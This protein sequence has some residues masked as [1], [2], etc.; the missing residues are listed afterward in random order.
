MARIVQ[1]L[2]GVATTQFE[3]D[4]PEIRIGRSPECDVFIDDTSVSNLHCV[5][6]TVAATDENQPPE[7]HIRD[8]DS[9]NGTYVNIDRVQKARLV[10]EDVIR[11]GLKNFKFVDEQS[12]SEVK[13]ARIKKSWIP[14]VY[15]TKDNK[16]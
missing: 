4:K 1:M 13:T 16:P 2:D 11:V 15:Y 3:I 12:A 6:E 14:G 7:Y 9:T 8:L 10:H 5:I